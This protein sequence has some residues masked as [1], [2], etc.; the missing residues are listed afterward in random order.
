MDVLGCNHG[1]GP[2]G[3]RRPAVKLWAAHGV[4][5]NICCPCLGT[6]CRYVPPK[7]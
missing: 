5:S 4:L 1:A 7:K 2:G 6:L 3:L